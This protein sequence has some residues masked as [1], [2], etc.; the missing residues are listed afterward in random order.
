LNHSNTTQDNRALSRGSSR[1]N[2]RGGGGGGG[3]DSKRKQAEDDAKKKEKDE[4][5]L[6]LTTIVRHCLIE[7]AFSE[8]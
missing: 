1:G 3:R 8:D 7:S 2:S 4:N 6:N 5:D